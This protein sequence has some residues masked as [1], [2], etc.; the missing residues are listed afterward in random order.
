M[1]VTS[2]RRK[3]Q[4]GGRMCSESN[5]VRAGSVEPG[6]PNVIVGTDF[7]ALAGFSP[8]VVVSVS[9]PAGDAVTSL[10][11]PIVEHDGTAVPL[12]LGRGE[13]WDMSTFPRTPI[14]V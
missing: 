8:S 2:K 11:A 9:V 14:A 12:D 6:Q 13:Y 10:S 1:S 3:A 5:F 7:R 4:T